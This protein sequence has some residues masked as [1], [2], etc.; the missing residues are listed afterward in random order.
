M[1]CFWKFLV[2]DS[3]ASL[4]LDLATT[5]ECSIVDIL[6]LSPGHLS[7]IS[8]LFCFFWHVLNSIP[9]FKSDY[10]H[11]KKKK[12]AL[13]RSKR[14]S[15]LQL[16]TFNKRICKFYATK[17]QNVSLFWNRVCKI[18]I[19]TCRLLLFCVLIC[20]IGI[21]IIF[22]NLCGWQKTKSTFQFNLQQFCFCF[23][24]FLGW[25]SS[26]NKTDRFPVIISYISYVGWKSVNMLNVG[27]GGGG[28]NAVIGLYISFVNVEVD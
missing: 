3:L 4:F 11:R 2:F 5:L 23:L 12:N 17:W 6:S 21:I 18:Y 25:F 27:G 1:W 24:F 16:S 22:F 9:R 15:V 20:C 19:F 28:W 10:H 8:A 14:P 26:T 7:Q 13:T